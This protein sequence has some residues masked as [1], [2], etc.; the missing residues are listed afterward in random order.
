MNTSLKNEDFAG[1]QWVRTR[2]RVL[3]KTAYSY[4]APVAMCQ[5][6]LKMTPRS[7]AAVEVHKC[8]VRITPTPDSKLIHTDYFGNEVTTFAIEALH[9]ELVIEVE[10]DLTVQTAQDMQSEPKRSWCELVSKLST[11]VR[12]GVLSVGEFVYPSP[13]IEWTDKIQNYARI[14]F[15]DDRPLVEAALDLTHRIFTDFK[16]DTS[17]TNVGTSVREAFQMKA[18][19]CQDFA[20]V[21]IACLRSLGLAARYV[22]GYLRTLP[23][24]GKPKLIGADESHAWCSVYTGEEGGWLDLDPTNGCL[25]GPNHIPIC[26]G[27][28]YL[29]VSPMCGIAV[30]GGTPSLGV[31]V[32]V[33]EQRLT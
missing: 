32:D 20:Q 31:S 26:W 30:G 25:T 10:S 8:D 22:S 11:P 27:R 24:P 13:K 9:D 7:S 6:Q 33:S 14:A 19:V 4:S 18:G 17:A 2:Y 1:D 15:T 21:Q 23:P 5:N 3:H 29:D 16:Y 28:D 12:S